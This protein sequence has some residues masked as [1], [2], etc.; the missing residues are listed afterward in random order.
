MAK[1]T[2][3]VV[4]TTDLD[5]YGNLKVFDK[6]GGTT[7]INKKHEYLHKLFEPGSAIKLTWDSYK[8]KEYVNDAVLVEGELPPP[9]KP[10]ILPDHQ[11]EVDKARASVREP[12]GQEIGLWWK[13]IGEGLRS[14]YF[15]KHIDRATYLA[16]DVAYFAQLFNVLD[17]K[18]VKIE[19]NKADNKPKIS[20]EV[21][22]DEGTQTVLGESGGELTLNGVKELL[23]KNGRDMNEWAK[24]V[25]KCF[26][27]DMTGKTVR[28]LWESL[29]KGKKGL[30]VG[31]LK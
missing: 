21:S 10:G 25:A 6:G 20:D 15:E 31:G 4:E 22:K 17:I 11:K 23:I 28:Q 5:D 2:V 26:D 27:F 13:E 1:E 24:E 12:S 14:G 7:R 8:G 19:T 16:M 30:A 3:I 18:E 29:D 9:Q